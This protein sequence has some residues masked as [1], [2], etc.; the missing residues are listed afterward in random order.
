M[1]KGYLTPYEM[2]AYEG[3]KKRLADKKVDQFLIK[4]AVLDVLG[5]PYA[6]KK[7]PKG[8]EVTIT[9]AEELAAKTIKSAIDNPNTIKL[10]DIASIAGDLKPDVNLNL[11][12]G[13]ELFG[14]IAN[15][16]KK[17]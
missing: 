5:S 8:E 3:R 13:L 12:G 11:Q 10:K 1:D 4:N 14:D 17:D 15:P 6:V 16:E 9:V 2:A 7:S